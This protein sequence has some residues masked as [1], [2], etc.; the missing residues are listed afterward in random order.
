MRWSQ[1]PAVARTAGLTKAYRR[2]IIVCMGLLAFSTRRD[3]ALRWPEML[4]WRPKH[5][6]TGAPTIAQRTARRTAMA[7]NATFAEDRR[8]CR[9]S[10]TRGHAAR[11]DGRSRADGHR[12]GARRRHH[13]ADGER[14]PGAVTAAGLLAVEKQGRHR[15]HRLASPAVAQMMESIM[16]VA[17]RRSRRG[18]SSR[19]A[20]AMR[21]CATPAPA[22][23]TSPAGWAWRW[24]TLLSP[25]ARSSWRRTAG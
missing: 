22:T 12:A 3:C 13:A 5:R 21:R 19:S 17:S 8:A 14:P 2:R 16:Q 18:A 6:T 9:R 15:Y 10:R 7:S 20:R 23:T 11:A 4:R 24:P 25:A 1:S